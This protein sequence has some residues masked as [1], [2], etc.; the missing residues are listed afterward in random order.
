MRTLYQILLTCAMLTGMIACE[1]ETKVC[2]QTLRADL[3]VHFQRDSAFKVPGSD[4]TAHL[5]RDTIMP[6]VTLYAIVNG[7]GRDSI[8]KKQPLKDIF[9]P[10]SPAADSSVFFLRVD[11]TLTPDTLTFR[12]KRNRHFISPGCGF[13][14]YFDLDTAIITKHTIDSVVINTKAVTS[15]N[16]THLTFFFFNQ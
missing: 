12:Y 1:N 15:S 2:D 16:D 7:V 13:G 11:S 6:K 10:L 3:H 9:M 5:I 4:T 8:N 14:F